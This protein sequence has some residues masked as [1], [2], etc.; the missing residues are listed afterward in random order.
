ML[1]KRNDENDDRS[2]FMFPLLQGFCFLSHVERQR[3]KDK[4]FK[5]E[6]IRLFGIEKCSYCDGGELNKAL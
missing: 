1:K 5:L 2:V 3:K 6:I 4:N